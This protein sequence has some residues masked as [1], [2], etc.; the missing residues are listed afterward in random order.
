M[1]PMGPPIFNSEGQVHVPTEPR[2]DTID[3][4]VTENPYERRFRFAFKF[5]TWVLNFPSQHGCC[6]PYD[7]NGGTTLAIAGDDFVVVAGDTRMST[8]YEIKSRNGTST[9]SLFVGNYFS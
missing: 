5:L 7:F 2:A 9:L 4:G 3:H 8:G 6:S 1:L